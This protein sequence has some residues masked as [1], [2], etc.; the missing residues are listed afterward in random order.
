MNEKARPVIE[1]LEDMGYHYSV[2]LIDISRNI[3]GYTFTL[4]DRGDAFMIHIEDRRDDP[5]VNDFLIWSSLKSGEKNW[6]GQ[7]IELGG[8]IEYSAMKF[9]MKFIDILKGEEE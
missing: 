2:D 7:L 8:C 1:Q 9:I 3:K 5:N 4:E 6:F